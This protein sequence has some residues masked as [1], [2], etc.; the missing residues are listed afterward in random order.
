MGEIYLALER[1]PEAAQAYT[2]YLTLRPGV[3]DSFV[4]ER[5]GDA[6]NSAGNFTGAI[7]AYKTALAAPHIGDDT[8][9]QIKIAQAV[10]SSGDTTSALDMYNS[11]AKASSDKDVKAQMDLFSGRINLALGQTPRLTSFFLT[12]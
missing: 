6:F 1:F 5:R 9:L 7:S 4:Q 3:L 10:A 2:T 11:I 12:P 8:A